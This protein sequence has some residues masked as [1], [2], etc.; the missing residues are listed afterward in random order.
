LHLRLNLAVVSFTLVGGTTVRAG[1][2]ALGRCF[3][4]RSV[5]EKTE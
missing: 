3:P 2:V 4:V 1:R 5:S